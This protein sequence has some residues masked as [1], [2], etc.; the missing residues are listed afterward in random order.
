MQINIKNILEVYKRDKFVN[1]LAKSTVKVNA[2]EIVQS[3]KK[4]FDTMDISR[5]SFFKK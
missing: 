5:T 4:Y 2:M 1:L 3:V